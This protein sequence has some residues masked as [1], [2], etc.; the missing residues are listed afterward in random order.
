MEREVAMGVL[1]LR[2]EGE[3]G[4]VGVGGA[5]GRAWGRKKNEVFRWTTRCTGATAVSVMVGGGDVECEEGD[6]KEWEKKGVKSE[7][8]KSN[9]RG[10]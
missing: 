9:K 6:M 5:A 7:R 8:K 3:G 2:T 10:E 4:E 1:G